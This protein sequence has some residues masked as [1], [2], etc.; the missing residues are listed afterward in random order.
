[1]YCVGWWLSGGKRE[2]Y[3]NCSMLYCVGLLKLGAVIGIS[4]VTKLIKIRIHRMRI[5]T[6]KIRR[7][8]IKAYQLEYNALV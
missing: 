7:L 3:Q 6:F 1:M 8:R 5:L 2:D 4:D